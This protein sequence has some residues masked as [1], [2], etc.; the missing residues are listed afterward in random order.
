MDFFQIIKRCCQIHAQATSL[1][2]RNKHW[3]AFRVW[4]YEKQLGSLM[5][6]SHS[7]RCRW[8]VIF[9]LF[10]FCVYIWSSG[11][12]RLPR[13][14]L[15]KQNE[16]NK[17]RYKHFSQSVNTKAMPMR[18]HKSKLTKSYFYHVAMSMSSLARWSRLYLSTK[19]Y[20]S[21]YW[22]SRLSRYFFHINIQLVSNTSP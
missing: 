13:S 6:I 10:L 14:R 9:L 20:Y 21:A 22:A 2:K 4:L 7:P 16:M 11:M 18:I 5:G 15:S 12:T 19:R 8:C 3:I 1:L 17:N